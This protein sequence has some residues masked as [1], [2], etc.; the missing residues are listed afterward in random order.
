MSMFDK[1]IF[2]SINHLLA[3]ESWATDRLRPFSGSQVLIQ[4]G[5][6]DLNL[7]IDEQ[8][9]LAVGDKTLMPDV[10]LTL[11]DDAPLR[12]LTDRASL[13]ASVKLS[14]SADIAESLAFVL[15]NLRWDVEADLANVLGDIAARRVALFGT[16]LAQQFQDGIKRAAENLA[17]YAAEDSAVL[18]PNREIRAFCSAVDTLRDDLAR[19]E[20]RLARL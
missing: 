13:F 15:R 4:T 10:T 20:K 6:G 12:L 17:E 16:Q 8:G 14:G 5:M 9:M 7:L 11:P 19:L 1:L 2:S 18:A 3:N